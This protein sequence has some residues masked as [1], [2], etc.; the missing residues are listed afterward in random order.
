MQLILCI[1]YFLIDLGESPGIMLS[2]K[3]NLKSLHIVWL[4]DSFLIIFLTW[5]NYRN[6]E[7]IFGYQGIPVDGD[8]REVSVTTKWQHEECCGEGNVLHFD[9]NS[10]TI[11]V[12]IS[13][14]SF[15]IYYYCGK[16]DKVY[17][18]FLS[19]ISYNCMP[20]YNYLKIQRLSKKI[21]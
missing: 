11:L 13:Y 2:E 17:I 1:K 14:Y 6:G 20:T 7:E 8:R 16:L 5:K 3:A 4:Y 19:T 10:V 9:C 15:A 21:L 18:E 12:V